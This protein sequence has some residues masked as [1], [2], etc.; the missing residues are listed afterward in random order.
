MLAEAM[1]LVP[2]WRSLP[3]PVFFAWY[4]DNGDRLMRFFAPLEVGAAVL[5]I[6]AAVSA[7]PPQRQWLIAASACA[8]AVILAFPVYFK[9]ANASFTAASVSEED[10]PAA[11]G[12][13]ARWHWVRVILGV[14]A[15]LASI[16]AV[17]FS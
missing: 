14:L 7:A 13:W 16:V 12:R 17:S 8:V 1:I 15:F 9:N 10:L 4:R 2:F 5:P 3:A 11:L 6:I